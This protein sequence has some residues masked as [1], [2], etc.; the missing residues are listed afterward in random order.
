MTSSIISRLAPSVEYQTVISKPNHLYL[1]WWFD[2]IACINN[3]RCSWTRYYAS[4][5]YLSIH[6]K[7]SKANRG[8]FTSAILHKTISSIF[9]TQITAVSGNLLT[10]NV[11]A[12]TSYYNKTLTKLGFRSHH[13]NSAVDALSYKLYGEFL[14]NIMIPSASLIEYMHYL[15]PNYDKEEYN[16]VHLR[17]GGDLADVPVFVEFLPLKSFP[18]ILRCIKQLPQ[19]KKLYVASD[20][21]K[22]KMR[23]AKR[24]TQYSLIYSKNQTIPADTQMMQNSLVSY[25][26]FSAV[27][28]LYI[29][30]HG[31]HCVMTTRSTYSLAMC[32]LTGKKPII[33]EPKLQICDNETYS[34][35][36]KFRVSYI[37]IMIPFVQS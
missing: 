10:I 17:F 1:W 36:I 4:F 18:L 31:K 9:P 11:I 12:M 30:G 23:L 32:A 33:I 8:N 26:T 14:R 29:L 16:A 3:C 7:Q 5:Y 22:M 27:A 34:I 19:P 37:T 28:E 13:Y 20:S 25:A 35:F 2:I 21:V 24:L 6:I 15:Y